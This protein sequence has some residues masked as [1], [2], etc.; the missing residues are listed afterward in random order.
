MSCTPKQAIDKPVSNGTSAAEYAIAIHGGAGTILKENMTPEAE[1]AYRQTLEA[2]LAVGENI[3]KNGGSSLD[4]VEQTIVF[5]E[6]SP[7]F[8]AGRGAVFTHEGKNELDA[9]IMSGADKNAGAVGG[10]TIVKNPIRAARAVMEKSPHVFLTGRGAE[11]FAIEQG[12]DTVPN[13]YFFTQD[14]WESLQSILE[15]ENKQ[16]GFLI[17]AN[18]DTKFGTVGCV[19]LDKNGQL[20]AGTSTGGMTNK[21]Y[22]RIGD[23]PI[24]GAGTYADNAT[25]AVS[26]TGHGEYFIRYAVAYDV[27]A[28]MKYAGKTLLEAGNYTINEQLKAAGGEGGL[29]AVDHKGNIAMPFNSE[30]MYRAYAKPNERYIGIY[31]ED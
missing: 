28:Q 26:C 25:C 19:A 16:S 1:A 24:I 9:S 20:A 27:S 21:R 2:A 6:E 30:G 7:L 17:N 29:I 3:L 23:A 13:T 14:R 5:L 4:A 11:Q 12:L 8:N 10:V 31:K 18:P 15:A 22:N